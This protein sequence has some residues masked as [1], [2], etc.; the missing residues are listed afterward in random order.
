[1]LL[2]EMSRFLVLVDKNHSF[3]FSFLQ[4]VNALVHLGVSVVLAL[5]IPG[6]AELITLIFYL[7][8]L[9]V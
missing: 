6:E 5:S 7:W 4:L 3:F 8:I 2:V 9:N 1:M